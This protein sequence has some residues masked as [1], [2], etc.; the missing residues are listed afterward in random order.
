MAHDDDLRLAS[1]AVYGSSARETTNTHLIKA[2][3]R[4]PLYTQ[5]KRGSAT[6]M[7][8]CSYHIT[9]REHETP[10]P[11]KKSDFETM[12]RLCPTTKDL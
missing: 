7:A 9:R 11:L 5:K 3:C 8:V 2:S 1:N 6:N 12:L 4:T 10:N